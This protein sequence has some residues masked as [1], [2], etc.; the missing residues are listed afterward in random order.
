MKRV[1]L[2]AASVFASVT[3]VS[4][5]E[6]GRLDVKTGWTLS[7]L[8]CASFSSDQG[9]QYGLFGDVYFFGDGSTYPEYLHD[10]GFEISHYTKGRTRLLANYDSK[11]LI[12]GIRINAS[13]TCVLD[14]FYNFYGFNGAA[15]P[16]LPSL[17]AN[18]DT[19][20]NYYGMRRDMLRVLA[21][22]QG[23]I[24]PH[25]NWAAGLAY[26]NY[27]LGNQKD[28]G[29]Y[30]TSVS[31]YRDYIDN[32]L[33]GGN[34]KDGG[35]R[36]ELKAGIVYDTRDREAAPNRGVWA[37]FYLGGSPD[38]TGDGFNYLKLNAHFRHYI[39]TPAR[40]DGGGI[41]LAYHLAYSGTLAGEVPFYMQQNIPTLFLRQIVSEG[42]GSSNTIR[43]FYCNRMV[44]DGYA[45]AN[46]EIRI[47]L[48]SFTFLRQFFYVAVNPFFDCGAVV[49][50]YRAAEMAAMLATSA[51]D[52][53]GSARTFEHS[54]GAGVK[55]AW[56][57][58]FV[59]SIELAKVLGDECLEMGPGTWINF[60]MGYAF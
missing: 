15:Q 13:V 19:R 1:L 37:E 6:T 18:H 29:Y 40:W 3:V 12:P 28:N 45:W 9:F 48:F 42:L 36:L 14:P 58:N 56:N 31:L 55:M 17:S 10:I 2:F 33:V 8:P 27:N 30:D 23:N 43:G 21:D 7:A 52:I 35:T 41:N 34:E 5:Q 54:A 50:P 46:V 38:I 24:L 51:G 53:A 11:Y 22:F 25:M 49:Q 57:E 32:G 26:W 59:M 60:S 20:I 16:Y 39:S 4:A 44:A 47:K